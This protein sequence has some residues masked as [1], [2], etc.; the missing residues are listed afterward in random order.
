[1]AP[2]KAP[3]DQA[4]APAPVPAAGAARPAQARRRSRRRSSTQASYRVRPDRPGEFER[5]VCEDV[6]EGHFSA[7]FTKELAASCALGGVEAD[8]GG[9]NGRAGGVV[10]RTCT[11]AAAVVVVCSAWL[12]AV[13]APFGFDDPFL[14]A[15]ANTVYFAYSMPMV[16]L[17]VYPGIVLY[18]MALVN[19]PL[20]PRRPSPVPRTLFSLRFQRLLW[21]RVSSLPLSA[22]CNSL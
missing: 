17:A 3:Q 12:F 20:R 14:G 21:H 2:I 11:A 7:S 5:V 6:E 8:G 4:G 22:L 9:A 13:F 1:M 15:G 16:C 18:F 19:V 10:R